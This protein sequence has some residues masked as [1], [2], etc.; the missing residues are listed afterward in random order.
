L[1]LVE[2]EL[3][4]F[5]EPGLELDQLLLVLL[6]LG[7]GEVRDGL[8]DLGREGDALL[9]E[10]LVVVVAVGVE[11]RDDLLLLLLI[12]ADRREQQRLALGL[13]DLVLH[14]FQA[15]QKVVGFRQ[16]ADAALQINGA[17]AAPAEAAYRDW[18]HPMCR[19]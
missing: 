3:L 19:S 16:H 17:G 6:K 9:D 7:E 12:E 5:G 14:D 13:R 10:L 15:T 1:C 2:V 4:D 18:P 8:C 11:A